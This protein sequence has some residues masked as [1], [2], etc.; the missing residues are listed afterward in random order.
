MYA[1]ILKHEVKPT[2]SVEK[3]KKIASK[4][5]NPKEAK[6][7]PEKKLKSKKIS[8]EEKISLITEKVNK[9]LDKQK[10][11]VLVIRTKKEFS[12]YITQAIHNDIIAIDT[13]TNNSLDPLTA[14]LM[15]L[16]VY[17][18]NN[19]KVYIPVNHVD[20][21]TKEKLP[22]Q[23]TEQDIKEEL[24]RVVDA[25]I[26]TIMHNAKFD[27]QVIKMTCGIEVPCY[28]D[29][30]IA[31]KLIDENE[32]AGLKQQYILH[33]DSEQEKYSI[34]D[35]FEKEE[36][37]IF[38]PEVFALY[39][40]T[41]P[42]MT[43]K[44]YEWQ[45]PIMESEDYK[46][47]NNLFREVEMP[48][49]RVVAEMEL[50]GIELDKE[51]AQRLSIKYH[52]KLDEL[53][54]RISLELKKYKTKI[55]EWRTTKEA[56]DKPKKK[57]KT[58]KE[59]QTEP[60]EKEGKSKSEQLPD[61]INLGSPT[62]L[63]ILLYD[64]IGVGQISKETP[65]GTGEDI[66]QQINLPLAKLILERRGL[67]KLLDAFIDSLPQKVNPV[68]GRVHGH[69]NQ[70]GAATGRFSSSDPNLQQLPASNKEIRMMFKARD[71]YVLV[72]SD[73]SQ[74]E[75]RMLS[76]YSKDEDMINAY[77]EG[78]DL[79][80]TIASSVYKNDYWDNMEFRQDGTPNPEGKKRRNACKTLLLGIMYGQGVM[81]VAESIG[82]SI[83]EAQA[84][85]DEFYDSFPKVKGW[86]DETTSFARK[87]GY[88]EDLWGRR[89]RLPDISLPRFEVT[90]KKEET[91]NT[92]F[93]PLL[94]ADESSRVENPLV[95]NYKKK[96]EGKRFKKEEIDSIILEASIQGVK[97]RNNGGFIAQAERQCVN[98]RIQG[99]SATMTKI[100]M[101]K[102]FRDD[103]LNKLGFKLL[104]TVHDELIGECPK[105]N[106]EKVAQ[107]LTS[108]MKT[109][110]DDVSSV[111][112]K[113]D[114]DINE[115]WYYNDYVNTL[116]QE[117][118]K[119]LPSLSKEDAVQ[120]VILEHTEMP[121]EEI[122]KILAE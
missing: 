101:N 58:I 114:A 32:L 95:T 94:G 89:R 100:A 22:N 28:W 49:I 41:D 84:I 97:I 78:K 39:A 16:C 31:A 75:P 79:Y 44:L 77:K 102:L 63:A 25:Q 20:Y 109:C 18:P 50:T 96:L 116:K 36:Y 117:Y 88:V 1:D 14:K 19:K 68:D 110:I 76:N 93:N 74:Q 21:K 103:E 86:M 51:Y 26:L 12:D 70:Y 6:I 54:N 13:E 92:V 108:I 2:S 15:G 72:G 7:S 59:G 37:A 11:D 64:V 3:N 90:M 38:P 17:T 57:S 5:K 66:L 34:E 91:E 118:K 120:N 105:E 35:L 4:A 45:K 53:D 52:N 83:P 42:Y 82:S 46:K 71:G 29:T 69:F 122:R 24:S 112:F 119:I 80:A 9:T 81:A 47:V 56:N 23:L 104:L 27:F 121:Q 40:A 43:Y 107:R 67:M 55:E 48:V 85:I 33:I 8:V 98:A 106:S 99:G 65:R 30:M 61:E 111:P 62:Q 115:H 87:H 10:D 60:E 113:C 73:F